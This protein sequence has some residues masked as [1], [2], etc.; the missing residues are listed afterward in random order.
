MSC[1]LHLLGTEAYT[2]DSTALVDGLEYCNSV[3]F[4]GRTNCPVRKEDSPERRPC[5]EWRVGI[6]RGHRPGRPD[7]DLQREVLHGQ[8][9]AAAPTTPRTSTRCS[10]TGRAPTRCARR[11]G[12][13]ARSSS[14]SE[15]RA[16]VARR[17]GGLD[18]ATAS[19]YSRSF[20]RALN[21]AVEC[22]L[23]TVEVEGSNPSAP[24]RTSGPPRRRT[25]PR[26]GDDPDPRRARAPPHRSYRY[27]DLVMAAFVTVL[28]CANLI[29]AAKVAQRRGAHLRRRRPL[30]PD[31]LRLRRHPHR[32]VRLRAGPQGRLGGLRRARLRLVHEL[33]HPGLPARS[34]LAA[35][36]GLRDRLRRDA[37]HRARL[38]RR[39]LLRRVLQLLRPREDEAPDRRTPP[40]EPDH[41]LH[42]RGRGGG[43]GRLLPARLPRR[44]GDRPRPAGHGVELP[45]QGA[46]GGRRDSLHLPH[47]ELPEARRERGLLRPQHRLHA[48][49]AARPTDASGLVRVSRSP[50]GATGRRGGP[51]P[52]RS[53]RGSCGRGRARAA[54]R[55]RRSRP[56]RSRGW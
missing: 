45:P 18:H 42:D 13:A 20:E 41:R 17:G 19:V 51:R 26:H 22:H 52:A 50:S 39:L 40:L 3:G 54:R 30:L 16:A 27:Y 46:V 33:G 21:S 48:L 7:L 9:R 53:G 5:E 24:T 47:R 29:G 6:R 44:L 34:R 28:L 1:K 31:Q 11:P 15:L 14:S 32:G 43:L 8:G 35:P 37:A 49:L 36:G 38:A 10:S 23:H 56:R 4:T 55:G 12:P 25:H 2:L